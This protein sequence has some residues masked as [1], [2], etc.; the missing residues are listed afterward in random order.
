MRFVAWNIRTKFTSN[1]YAIPEPI[2]T[3][4]RI[5][6]KQPDLILLPL[7]GFDNLGNRIGMG[8]GYYDRYLGNLQ[9]K[10]TPYLIGL[11]F[12]NQQ[13]NKI[14]CEEFDVPLNAILT[15]RGLQYFHR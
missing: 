13:L 8:G 1:R 2:E 5:E 7:L 15:E 10:K 6:L 11:G 3:V 12:H 14:Q 4:K 9:N